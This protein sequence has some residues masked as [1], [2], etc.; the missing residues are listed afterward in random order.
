MK[1]KTGDTASATASAATQHQQPMPA[2]MTVLDGRHLLDGVRGMELDE[3]VGA[4]GDGDLGAG[5]GPAVLLEEGG[6]V[7]VGGE[8]R[9]VDRPR[10]LVRV[11]AARSR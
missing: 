2:I 9:D 11:L 3:A 1:K 7:H 6:E 4:G 5:D 10:R 8:A